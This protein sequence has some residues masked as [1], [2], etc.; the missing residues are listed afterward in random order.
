[1]GAHLLHHL[2]EA[3]ARDHPGRPAVSFEGATLTYAE[4][5]DRA[6][7]LAVA[8]QEKGVSPGDRVGLQLRKGG[9]AV[10]AMLA[11]LKAGAAYVPL[12]PTVPEARRSYIRENS[13]I[14]VVLSSQGEAGPGLMEVGDQAFDTDPGRLVRHPTVETDLAY[15]LYTSGST[16][17]PKGVAISHLNSLTFV[18]WAGAELAVTPED[19]LA[20]HAPLNFDL[21]VL[22]IYCALQAGACVCPVPEAIRAFPVR[23]AEWIETERITIWYSVPSAL[24]LLVERGRLDHVDLSRLRLVLF[25]GEVYPIRSLQSLAAAVPHPRYYNLY[26]PTETNVCT[27]HEVDLERLQERTEPLPIGR[28]CQNMK[29]FAV[30]EAGREAPAGVEGELLVGGSGVAVGY[31]DLPDQTAARFVQNPLQNSYRDIVYRTGDIVIPEADGEYRFLGRRDDQVKVHGY[32][33]E[34]GELESALQLMP[35]IK[36]GAAIAVPGVAGARLEVVVAMREGAALTA[37]DIR[38]HCGR[39]LPPYMVPESVVFVSALPR[40]S[41]GKV[42]RREL[43]NT[44]KVK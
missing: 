26:G 35:E 7:R 25:A 23:I 8:L 37:A 10:T 4:L 15:I 28:A 36:E 30:D 40:N 9:S 39:L 31:W 29:V 11:V 41:N 22:D 17:T 24:T 3:G 34:L 14:S 32:R 44:A 18:R 20:N 6:N 43:L 38:G 33:I 19:R 12:D 1:M 16:G 21:S 13:G 42:D 27:F 5:D 2:V